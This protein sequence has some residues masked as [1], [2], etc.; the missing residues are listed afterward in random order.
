HRGTADRMIEDRVPADEGV[1]GGRRIGR[2][3]RG[4]TDC[5]RRTVQNFCKSVQTDEVAGLALIGAHAERG[6][7]LRMLDRGVVL[8]RR[9]CDILIG[10]IVLQVDP[11]LATPMRRD[12]PDEFRHC[13]F[14]RC[15]M[16]WGRNRART[17]PCSR[18][19]R[20]TG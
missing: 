1:E 16:R 11:A 19:R 6:V 5:F 7:T 10:D 17:D 8:A 20:G 13:P 15:D 4:Y 12:A 14:L 3:E 2:T 9:E 18:S